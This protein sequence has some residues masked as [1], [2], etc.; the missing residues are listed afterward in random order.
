[1]LISFSLP[2]FEHIFDHVRSGGAGMGTRGRAILH[3]RLQKVLAELIANGIRK[4]FQRREKVSGQI[5]TDLLV[6]YVTSTFILVLNWWVESR[7][8][9]PTDEINELFRALVLPTGG[10]R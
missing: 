3:V 2:I 8:P 7:D 9:L 1:R 10:D 4:D 6:Q 5:P